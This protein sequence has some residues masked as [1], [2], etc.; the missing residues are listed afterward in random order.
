MRK[1]VASMIAMA[2][3]IA[4]SFQSHEAIYYLAP[5]G[6]TKVLAFLLPVSNKWGRKPRICGTLW[7]R[8]TRSCGEHPARPHFS[9]ARYPENYLYGVCGSTWLGSAA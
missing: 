9:E 3:E 5:N 7:I 1:T 8:I 2:R 6:L 4:R